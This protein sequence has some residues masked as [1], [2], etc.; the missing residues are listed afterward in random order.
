MLMIAVSN[1][2]AIGWSY[3]AAGGCP[4][5]QPFKTEN[6]SHNSMSA[7]PRTA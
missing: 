7:Y 2:I 3:A 5:L 1:S 4:R 6:D